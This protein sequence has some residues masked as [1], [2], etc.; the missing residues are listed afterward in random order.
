VVT[1]H[2]LPALADLAQLGFGRARDRAAGSAALGLL[3]RA[4]EVVVTLERYRDHLA[5][6]HGARR[7][8]HIPHGL[9][10]APERLAEPVE[11]TLLVFGTFGPHKDPGLVAEAVARL[12]PARPGLR[13][14]VAGSD[15]PRHPG[16]MAECRVRHGLNGSW[17]GYVSRE[18]LA[19][20][21]A[22]ASIVVV[23]SVAS[24][25]A[26]GVIHRAI[27]HGR[28]VLVSDLPD[29]RALAAEEDLQLAWFEPGNVAALADAIDALLSDPR[30]RA[31]IATHNLRSAARLTPS[32]TVEAY[33]EL[34][35][36][37]DR[38]ALRARRAIGSPRLEPE[39]K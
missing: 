12:R 10:A 33:L 5:R 26:S 27:G 35:A 34:F 23:P 2:E 9:W 11:D 17:L 38:V 28:A 19:S 8:R 32:R 16:F 13:L 14:L 4:D 36:G 15:H 3:L 30:H 31:A 1:I 18:D 21:F 39:G 24:T 6:H 22:R 29:F 20:L 7:V 25:G 37:H